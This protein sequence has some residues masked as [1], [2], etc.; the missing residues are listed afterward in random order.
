LPPRLFRRRG[1]FSRDVMALFLQRVGG[2]RNH[3][4]TV[5]LF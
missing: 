4:G 2:S 5:V 3:N 1:R